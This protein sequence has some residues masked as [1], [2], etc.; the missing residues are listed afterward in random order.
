MLGANGLLGSSLLEKASA[1]GQT[2]IGVSGKQLRSIGFPNDP[3]NSLQNL[4]IGPGDVVINA[5]GITKHRKNE[6]GDPF[7]MYFLNASLPRILS[8]YAESS[9]FRVVSPATDCVFSGLP[10]PKLEES[11]HDATDDYGLSKSLGEVSSPNVTLIRTSFVGFTKK[12]DSGQLADWLASRPR[13][14]RIG[15]YLNHLWSGVPAGTLSRVLL[16]A[17]LDTSFPKG[18]FHLVPDGF[19]T[20]AA[21]LKILSQVTNRKDITIEDV[22]NADPID[23]VLSTGFPEV[24]EAMWRLAGYGEAPSIIRLF[25]TEFH[26]DIA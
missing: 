14:E 5:L 21:L 23:R 3:I 24:N 26:C 16:G 4:E 9:G 18:T 10:G 17:A 1:L 7:L 11:E 12:R 15:G 6:S 20:K 19:L 8:R 2:V 22:R 13:F 25:E